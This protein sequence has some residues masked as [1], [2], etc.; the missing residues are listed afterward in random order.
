MTCAVAP[1]AAAFHG[2]RY[3]DAVKAIRSAATLHLLSLACHA[4]QGWW[5]TEPIRWLQTNLADADA[6]QDPRRFVAQV[7]D[8]DANVL[9]MAIVEFHFVNPYMR[10]TRA[11]PPPLAADPREVSPCRVR[12]CDS[13]ARSRAGRSGRGRSRWKGS[14]SRRA[15]RPA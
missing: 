12:W 1:R 4:Q 10:L 8:F 3:G 9:L 15:A 14:S 11:A 7:A 5:M 6:P 2:A 13:S